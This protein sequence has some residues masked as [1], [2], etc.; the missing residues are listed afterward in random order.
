[1]GKMRSMD[2]IVMIVVREI[3]SNSEVP[4]IVVDSVAL[5]CIERYSQDFRDRC[6]GEQQL[7]CELGRSFVSCR[8][9]DVTA[10]K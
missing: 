6:R 9:V 8:Q 1:M 4:H 7:E 10:A 3:A 2:A 5:R